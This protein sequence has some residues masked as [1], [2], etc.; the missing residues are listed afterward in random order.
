MLHR[1]YT[2]HLPLILIGLGLFVAVVLVAMDR[3]RRGT[4]VFGIVTVGAAA[5]RLVL[6]EDR[7]GVLAVRSRLF[8][9]ATLA[10][11]GGLVIWLGASI[12][13]LGTG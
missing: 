6:S 5:I 7:V 9:V 2:I 1:L 3:W 11:F 13:S 8:D 4:L 12:E 10:T